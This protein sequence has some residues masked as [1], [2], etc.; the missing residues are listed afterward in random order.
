MSVR[1]LQPGELVGLMAQ[2]L[3]Y[4]FP[5]SQH[6]RIVHDSNRLLSYRIKNN[7][8]EPFVHAD[9]MRYG[10]IGP[11][12]QASDGTYG[13]QEESV[14]GL[15]SKRRRMY[16][17]KYRMEVCK[18]GLNT[19]ALKETRPILVKTVTRTGRGNAYEKCGRRQ[20]SIRNSW[21]ETPCQLGMV[22]FIDLIGI[23]CR[24]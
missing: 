6:V 14:V 1:L 9:S 15:R 8:I 7:L 21:V 17:G 16:D 3:K 13:E 19:H 23:L 10:T 2:D 18:I 4:E 24:A 20:L 11:E 22:Q 12:K 5:T